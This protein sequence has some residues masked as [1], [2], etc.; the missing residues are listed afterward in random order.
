M[1]HMANTNDTHTTHT[2]DI[3]TAYKHD[4]HITN[5][6]TSRLRLCR[7]LPQNLRDICCRVNYN[8]IQF[9]FLRKSGC[10]SYDTYLR[11]CKRVLCEV[12]ASTILPLFVSAHSPGCRV[13]YDD[14]FCIGQP[15]VSRI[16]AVQLLSPALSVY[17]IPPVLTMTDIPSF[18]YIDIPLPKNQIRQSTVLPFFQSKL[19]CAVLSRS[20]RLNTDTHTSWIRTDMRLL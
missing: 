7:L 18:P 20:R 19:S 2:R 3:N 14:L 6:H 4:T 5:T 11:E 13:L 9:Q 12:A 10:K 8:H 1:T 17:S 16:V 15:I